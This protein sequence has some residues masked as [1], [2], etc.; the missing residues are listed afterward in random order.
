MRRHPHELDSRNMGYDRSPRPPAHARAVDRGGHRPATREIAIAA[1]EINTV[2]AP[3]TFRT[4]RAPEARYGTPEWGPKHREWE[5]GEDVKD[6]TTDLLES[7]KAGAQIVVDG[8]DN[9][10]QFE[11]DL[12]TVWG[13]AALAV[14]GKGEAEAAASMGMPPS[15]WER[16]G[17][18][19]LPFLQPLK[20]LQCLALRN[21]PLGATALAPL[22][23]KEV[24]VHLH[25]LRI[26][27][28]AS[29][30]PGSLAPLQEC[31]NLRLLSFAGCTSLGDAALGWALAAQRLQTLILDSTNCTD[32]T[33]RI[34][35]FF[36]QLRRLSLKGNDITNTG[37]GLVV[38]KLKLTHLRL[39]GC[40]GLCGGVEDVLE[41]CSSL[42]HVDLA[43]CG[44]PR[45]LSKMIQE[46]HMERHG[47]TMMIEEIDSYYE[48]V[49][50]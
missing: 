41:P 40:R 15:A 28:C 6:R 9:G 21:L 18:T 17:A 10:E 36:L 49:H 43:G 3:M 2:P 47:R 27:G 32:R 12:G 23:N 16:W 13:T 11:K 42:K 24:A 20:H 4:A 30:A 46:N 8:V 34:A 48:P 39:Q 7:E 25:S 33:L 5:A 29:L 1:S 38:Q 35:T 26:E 22:G 44:L 37:L 14:V 45:D 19:A 31:E 50:L